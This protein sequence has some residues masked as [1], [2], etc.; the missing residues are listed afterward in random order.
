[1]MNATERA[2]SFV[3]RVRTTSNHN[4][5]SKHLSS[6]QLALTGRVQTPRDSHEKSGPGRGR[7]IRADSEPLTTDKWVEQVFLTRQR[8]PSIQRR[9]AVEASDF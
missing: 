5:L 6:P 8:P 3:F 7:R 1:M 9:F 2:T 4:S